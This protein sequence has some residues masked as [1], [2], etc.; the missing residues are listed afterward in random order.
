[1]FLADSYSACTR[2]HFSISATFNSSSLLCSSSAVLCKSTVLNNSA[3]DSFSISIQSIFAS[4]SLCALSSAR[5]RKTSSCF[6]YPCSSSSSSSA[7]CLNRTSFAVAS[8]ESL[9]LTSTSLKSVFT[10]RTCSTQNTSSAKYFSHLS[11]SSLPTPFIFFTISCNCKK[12]T[13]K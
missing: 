10:S 8:A 5:R 4:K 1:S 2:L 6:L 9:R 11:T 3:S 12:N 7:N 13:L